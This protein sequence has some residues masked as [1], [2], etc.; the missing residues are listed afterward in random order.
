MADSV[1]AKIINGLIEAFE[2]IT[3]P[4]G[5]S[6]NYPNT[7][8]V[9]TSGRPYVRLSVEKNTPRTTNIGGGME[10]ER[11]GNF[12]AVVCWPISEGAI[13]PAEVA[14]LIRNRFAF[15]TKIDHDGIRIWIV[16]EPAV[17]GDIQGSIY[18]ETPVVIPYHV[19]P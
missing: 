14:G 1:E 12:M 16:E 8:L 10:P 3:L 7:G 19:Y 17:V 5:V 11:M 15:N 6:I 9:P 13:K 2:D 4:I 18:N